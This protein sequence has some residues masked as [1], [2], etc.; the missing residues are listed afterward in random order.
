MSRRF[1][2]TRW[3]LSMCF[4]RMNF[5]GSLTS[6]LKDLNKEDQELDSDNSEDEQ[7]FNFDR[8]DLFEWERRRKIIINDL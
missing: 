3:I 2:E 4:K 7:E 6:S 1:K 5:D 8:N